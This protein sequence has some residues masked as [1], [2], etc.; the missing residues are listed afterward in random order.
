MNPCG[1]SASTTQGR[2]SVPPVDGIRNAGP[3][4]LDHARAPRRSRAPNDPG[5][6]S[7]RVA[8]PTPYPASFAASRTRCEP[9]TFRWIWFVPS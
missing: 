6:G 2:T 3:S 1:F 4:A 8:K 7:P 9:I 5:P